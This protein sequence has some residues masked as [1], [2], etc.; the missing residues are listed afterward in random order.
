MGSSSPGVTG[1][2][3][4]ALIFWKGSNQVLVSS[5]WILSWNQLRQALPSQGPYPRFSQGL[6]EEYDG[7]FT[8]L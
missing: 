8:P 4:R 5:E 1:V 2:R 6:R 3:V 7:G